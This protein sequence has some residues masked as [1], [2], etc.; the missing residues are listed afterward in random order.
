MTATTAKGGEKSGMMKDALNRYFG[1]ADFRESQA[2]VVERVL[3]GEELCVIMPTGAGKSLCYQLPILMRPGYGLVISPLISLMKD[4]VDALNVRGLAAVCV[5]S[6]IPPSEQEAALRAVAAGQ[7]KFLYV[8]PERFQVQSFRHFLDSVRPN[9]IV[10]DEAHCVS[11]WGHDFRP[12]YQM[13]WSQCEVLQQMQVCAFTATATPAVREDIKSQLQRPAMAELVSGFKRPN[14]E[15]S[16]LPCRGKKDKHAVMERLLRTPQPTLIYTSSRREAE[17]LASQ[18]D[19]QY[20]HA[21]MTDQARKAAQDYFI[22]DACPTLVATNAFGMGIDR[23]DVRR[24]IHYNMPGSLEAYY[25]EAGRAGRDGARSQ[26]ILLESYPDLLIQQYLLD[27]NNP[28]PELLVGLHRH[29]RQQ[30]SRSDG[31]ACTWQPEL[32]WPTL[33]AAKNAAQVQAAA[34]ILERLGIVQRTYVR[35]SGSGRLSFRGRLDKLCR[36]HAGVQTQR[37]LLLATVAAHLQARGLKVWHGHPGELADISGLRLDQVRRVLDYFQGDVLDWL[38]DESGE[39]LVLTEA[40]QAPELNV[41][42]SSLARK[43]R[44]DEQRL[45]LV[46]EYCRSYMCRQA[47]IISYFGEKIGAWRCGCCDICASRSGKH[48]A[49]RPATPAELRDSRRI[50]AALELI[51]GQFGRR[52]FLA[53]LMG[54][55]NESRVLQEHPAYGTMQQRG[56]RY[57]EELLDALCRQGYIEISKGT[58]PVLELSERG[59]KAAQDHQ[60]LEL[61]L[62]SAAK[63]TPRRKKF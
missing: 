17:N 4:Q 22:R 15:M 10:V 8:A 36:E 44:V 40:G 12:D 29:L 39:A 42:L 43:R 37:S 34:R 33:P 3:K 48:V 52:R 28:P 38:P 46:R 25:Q 53:M 41:D 26:C 62:L 2:E 11:Q 21:G 60:E 58:Y 54:L 47:F 19:L 13:I 61:S 56:E 1:Y 30:E 45:D 20:Y 57:L 50:L 24:V 9:L 23:A 55:E 35:A 63:K 51:D 31:A 49:G 5:N 59:S 32:V 6:A 14:L 27:L 7:V 16:V 18:F